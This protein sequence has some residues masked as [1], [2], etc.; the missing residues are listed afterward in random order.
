MSKRKSFIIKASGPRGWKI[1]PAEISV[2]VDGVN[3][4]CSKNVDINFEFI[5]FGITGMNQ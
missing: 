4:D 5:G 3:D 1:E 2:K